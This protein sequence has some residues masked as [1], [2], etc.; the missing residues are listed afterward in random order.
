MLLLDRMKLLFQAMEGLE[1]PRAAPKPKFSVYQNPTVS[2]ALKAAS[3]RPSSATVFIISSF[4]L[5]SA[6]S[7]FAITYRERELVKSLSLFYLYPQ[8]AY[9]IAKV[10][11][12]VAGL[13]FLAT[14]SSLVK[15]L[16][17]LS[18]IKPFE[19]SSK[20]A[21][22]GHSVLSERQ[23]RLLGM[24]PKATAK[25]ANSEPVRQS[26]T[27]KLASPRSLSE[28]LV[29]IRK[30][31]FSYT[32]SR[33]MRSSSDQQS[34]NVGKTTVMSTKSPPPTTYR[35]S[36]PWSRRSPGSAKGIL[37]EEMLEDFLADVDEKIMV[38][39]AKAEATPSTPVSGFGIASPG[40]FASSTT[41]PGAGRSAPLRPVFM[42]PSSH[43]K[44]TTPPKKGERELPPP[45]SMEQTVEAFE[46]LGIYPQIEWWRDLLRQWFSS[47]LIKPLLEKI[48]TSHV[49]VMQAAANLGMTITANKIG[50]DSGCI[51]P[52]INSSPIER[53]KE[54]QPTVTLD[55]DG[56]LHQMRASLIQTRDGSMSSLPFAGQQQQKQIALLPLIQQCVDAIT[57]HQ[58]LKTLMK[59]ELIKGLLPQSNVPA[60]Y[61][62]NRIRNL[63]EGTCLKNFDYVGNGSDY[64]NTE[65]KWSSDVPTD[66]HLLLYLFCAFMEHPKWMLH[67]DPSSYSGAQSSKNPLFLGVLPPKDRFPEKYV[68][69]ISSVPTVVHPGA[70][71]LSIGK[72]RPVFALYWDKKLHFSLH[73]RTASWD[74]ILLLCHRIKVGYG[75]VVR[76]VHLGSSAFNI[77]QILDSERDG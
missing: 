21:T 42:S 12:A 38:S 70:C 24:K 75:G 30:S 49:Q 58:R 26:Q 11:Q 27:S 68:A 6:I 77:L 73:G 31:A 15:L 40:S 36:T 71:I 55:E 66:S 59:G 32:P 22:E 61:T 18:V 5:A 28:A 16:S 44:Y 19:T 56:L 23:L 3:L 33:S 1:T 60:E 48:E 37:T 46:N 64:D 43:Q 45:L 10:L 20:K 35:T 76:G 13:L 74:A 4:F 2:A 52:P 57:E 65:K 50:C 14:L 7:V 9:L 54:W 63:A 51:L 41:P 72:Q 69:V 34:S 39:D 47:V 67:V 8:K 29:P 17:S 25:D 62:V 53:M